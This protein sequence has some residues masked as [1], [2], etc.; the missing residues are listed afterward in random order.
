VIWC[1]ERG[2][3]APSF[4][5]IRRF[6]AMDTHNP[7]MMGPIDIGLMGE[8]VTVLGTWGVPEHVA[9]SFRSQLA[10]SV[11]SAVSLQSRITLQQLVLDA[12]YR[13]SEPE[14]IRW[15]E[16]IFDDIVITTEGKEC[17]PYFIVLPAGSGKS[18]I[19][20]ITGWF[21][22]DVALRPLQDALAPLKRAGRWAEVNNA[23]KKAVMRLTGTEIVLLHSVDMV[24][25][26]WRY[27]VI[28]S[29]RVAIEALKP[30]IEDRF[31]E[32]RR[33]TLL[34][35][36]TSDSS[37]YGS[38]ALLQAAVIQ[39]VLS[40]RLK[41]MNVF[42]KQWGSAFN[43][44]G[45]KLLA[46]FPGLSG[47]VGPFLDLGGAP[48]CWSQML[49]QRGLTGIGVSLPGDL[50]WE[51]QPSNVWAKIDGDVRDATFRSHLVATYASILSDI[52]I[53]KPTAIWME[54][55][56]VAITLIVRKNLKLGGLCVVKIVA[57]SV[58]LRTAIFNLSNLFKTARITKPAMSRDVN[59]E[60]Y[61]ILEGYG[62]S[63]KL[64]LSFA[65]TMELFLRRRVRA[66]RRW[67]DAAI[68]DVTMSNVLKSFGLDV[69]ELPTNIRQYEWRIFGVRCDDKSVVEHSDW[70]FRNVG[71]RTV[72]LGGV[73]IRLINTAMAS[74]LTAQ[75]SL[76]ALRA[77]DWKYEIQRGRRIHG[78]FLTAEWVGRSQHHK[79]ALFSIS[80][81]LNQ[82][83]AWKEVV[84]WNHVT[85]NYPVKLLAESFS[86]LNHPRVSGVVRN[87][88]WEVTTD[89]FVFR[90]WFE[91]PARISSYCHDNKLDITLYTHTDFVTLMAS[92]DYRMIKGGNGPHNPR[93]AYLNCWC[94]YSTKHPQYAPWPEFLNTQTWWVKT[95]T[96]AL[97]SFWHQGPDDQR[98]YRG[99]AM[100][101]LPVHTDVVYVDGK[102]YGYIPSLDVAVDT[103]GHAISMLIM[104]AI[105]VVDINRYWDTVSAMTTVALF[106]K[107]RPDVYKTLVKQKLLTEDAI[108]FPYKLWHSYWDFLAAVFTYII[109][110]KDLLYPVNPWVIR[111]SVKRLNE[112][113]VKHPEFKTVKR[114]IL[115]RSVKMSWDRGHGGQGLPIK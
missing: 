72:I 55:I 74:C 52:G 48:G 94:T 27:R 57:D 32:H 16:I 75:Y 67:L 2:E 10:F 45:L 22:I 47:I 84:R 38:H 102:I 87:G 46:M 115:D 29:G 92:Q 97:R 85:F 19:S 42:R 81:M 66:T 6:M 44:A 31:G 83:D 107:T 33:L 30:G 103:S 63:S 21:D 62:L 39:S 101:R 82:P 8:E 43:R 78:N 80:N 13:T 26:Q 109:M 93:D 105:G 18:T 64:S 77:L 90:D 56:V 98:E 5:D 76:I 36:M 3:T 28:F 17:V 35:N 4:P 79:V 60:Y 59:W 11:N 91:D 112:L 9:E 71:F 70:R 69:V 89:N 61:L 15:R 106:P 73:V 37:V 99:L 86:K 88:V 23:T 40:N 1:G 110:A 114:A 51:I 25:T 95:P 96:A 54:E 20:K 108:H 50:A 14:L 24:P 49:L 58:E 65:T 7:I 111:L 12:C 34:N 53:Q 104:S 68:S 100:L 113:A 41:L